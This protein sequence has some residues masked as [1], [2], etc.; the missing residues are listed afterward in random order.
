MVL[1]LTSRHRY[2]AIDRMGIMRES[3][4]PFIVVERTFSDDKPETWE[5]AEFITI[6][7]EYI[8]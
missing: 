7:A 5:N 3:S 4:G 6:P 2:P 1:E 8:R